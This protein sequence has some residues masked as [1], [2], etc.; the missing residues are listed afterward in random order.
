VYTHRPIEELP[1]I[2]DM[3]RSI[4]ARSVW[5]QSGRDETGAGDPRGCWLPEEES[6]R[7]RSIVESAGLQYVESPYIAEAVRADDSRH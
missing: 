2:A 4:G 6:A 7:A 3:A 5:I 1:E